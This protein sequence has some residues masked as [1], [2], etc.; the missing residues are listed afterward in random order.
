MPNA[1]DRETSPYLLQHADNPVDWMPWGDAA[2]ERARREDKPIFLSIGYST[3]H[4]CHVMAHESFESDATAALLNEHFIS[5]KVDR[6]ERPDVDRVYMAYVQTMTGHGGWPL[7]AWLTPDLKPFYGGT[8]YPP[9]DRHGRAGFPTVLRAIARGWREERVKLV[10]EGERALGLLR[11]RA[12]GAGRAETSEPL[13][14]AAG[15][16]FEEGFR[17]YHES[18]DARNGGFGGAPKFPRASNL[19]FL[20]RVVALQGAASELGAEAMR[21]ATSTLRAMARGGI[22]D[23]VG[24]G[25]HRYSVDEGWLV[26]HFEK[27][28]YDQAQI[29]V[30]CLEARQATGDE[31]YAWLARDILGYVSRDLAAPGGGF[32]TAEDADS[33]VADSTGAITGHAEGAFYVWTPAELRTA[34]ADDAEFAA[35]HFGVEEQG[36]VPAELDPQ[37]EL[38]GR[39]ILVQRRGLAETARQFGLDPEAANDRLLSVVERLR[40]ARARR[41]RPHLDD[42]VLTSCNALMISAFARAYRV[43]GDAEYLA[44]ATAAADFIA[45]ELHDGNRGV[46]FR[47]WRQGVRALTEGFAE[48]YAFLIQALLDLHEASF[49]VRWLQWAVWLQAK[50]DELFWD[51]AAGGYFNSPGWDTS[52]MIRLKEDYD[53]AEPAPSSVAA[54]NLLRLGAWFEA[55][56]GGRSYRERGRRVLEAFRDTWSRAPQAMPQML[57]ALELAL[58]P[59]RHVVIAGDPRAEDFQALARV[60][61]AKFGPYR[62]VAAADGGEGQ[63][64][65]AA[66]APWIGAMVPIG[67]RATAYVCEEFSCQAPVTLSADLER[68]LSPGS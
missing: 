56:S 4:W 51:E 37:G 44:T 67:G 33:P 54:L 5:I 23:Q 6:E 50:M 57:C 11:A 18:F 15:R 24:G 47:S 25:F 39:N 41:P 59:A 20:L 3:C 43:L 61:G 29:A 21:L 35:W 38:R 68:L 40:S 26:P 13:V 45:R 14:E 1:L 62:A 8:Y 10:A 27:M 30:N 63:A 16:A 12:E 53:G 32:F 22:H 31:R 64:W 48:D 60:V 28:L 34:L 58:E 36:N 52:I 17:H 49:E 2:F 46:L 9:E 66:R 65:L 55:D 19:A 7:S 42:K